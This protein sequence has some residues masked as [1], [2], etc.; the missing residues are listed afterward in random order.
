VTI[1]LRYQTVEFGEIDIHIR[2]LRDN[3]QYEDKNQAAEKL[4]ISS[5]AWPLFGI[6]WPSSFELAKYI[7]SLDIANKRILEVGCGIGLSSLLLNHMHA[8]ITATDIHPC[9]QEFLGVN[10]VLNNDRVIPF[11]RLDWNSANSTLGRFDLIIGSDLLYESNHPVL[12]SNFIDNHANKSC[13]VIIIDPGRGQQGKFIKIMLTMGY[14]HMQGHLH[15]VAAHDNDKKY[16]L[17]R[18]SR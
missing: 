10:T 18:F 6:L 1:R 11:E 13:E 9:A 15:G 4:G 3:Q 8:D 17:M 2:T 14:S 16:K 7:S 12:L 5:A